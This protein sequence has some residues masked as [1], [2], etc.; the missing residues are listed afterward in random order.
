MSRFIR[1]FEA[2]ADAE[3]GQLISEPEDT[4]R[5]VIEDF[6]GVQQDTDRKVFMT[7]DHWIEDETGWQ[8]GEIETRAI[9]LNMIPAEEQ[10]QD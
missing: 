9:V 4:G 1:V 3:T 5:V 6:W 2:D 10:E 7:Y 8:T